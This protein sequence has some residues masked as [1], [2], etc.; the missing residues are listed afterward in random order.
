[1]KERY[2]AL[3]IPVYESTSDYA[4]EILENLRHRQ[5]TLK[6]AGVTSR[7]HNNWRSLGIVPA[8]E[9]DGKKLYFDF[10]QYL[11]LQLV[12]D[13]RVF[14]LPLETIA[15]VKDY[16][17]EEDFMA[18]VEYSERDMAELRRN[19]EKEV[20]RPLTDG[21]FAKVVENMRRRNTFMPYRFSLIVLAHFL[22]RSNTYIYIFTDSRVVVWSEYE[23]Q[24]KPD[25]GEPHITLPLSHY[26][27]QFLNDETKAQFVAKI[28]ILTREEHEVL[29]AMRNDDVKELTIKF[30]KKGN[31]RRA[32]L[33]TKVDKQLS[34]RQKKEIA[35]ILGTRDYSTITMK[36]Q[37]GTQLTFEEAQ[38]TRL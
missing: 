34:D 17:F 23:T 31:K 12:K 36:T 9:E 29:R 19:I 3:D 7:V 15:A 4:D 11:W 38:R 21:E 18:G 8:S 14:G 1:M 33:I 10:I 24:G 5:F 22:Y 35:Q 26:F 27:F 2:L 32:D 37:N 20:Q 30:S 6:D 16:L 13:L 25:L 28:P